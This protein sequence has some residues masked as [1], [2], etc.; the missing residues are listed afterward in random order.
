[1][2]VFSQRQVCS[3][4]AAVVSVL[5]RSFLYG[6]GLFEVRAFMAARL[7]VAEHFDRFQRARRSKNPVPFG[8]GDLAQQALQLIERNGCGIPAA[9][10]ALARRGIAGIS[11]GARTAGTGHDAPSRAGCGR[12][13]TAALRVKMTAS[14]RL[15][16]MSRWRNSRLATNSANP[17]TAE[18]KRR[19]DEA[20]LL[21][22]T[23]KSWRDRRATSFG[24]RRIVSTRR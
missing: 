8:E 23:A 10:D 2:I 21:T 18:R 22:R 4:N 5:D 20:L 14:F 16:P 15:P 24:F 3:R 6:D 17:G 9:P 13:A 12:A 7:S 1:M 19:A 11:P